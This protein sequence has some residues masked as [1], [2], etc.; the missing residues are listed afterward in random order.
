VKT[1]SAKRIVSYEF[2][3]PSCSRKWG[4]ASDIPGDKDEV[5]RL[6]HRRSVTLNCKCGKSYRVHSDNI[7]E[8]CDTCISSFMAGRTLACRKTDNETEPQSVCNEWE[9]R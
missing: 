7:T 2:S 5:D 8:E 1:A 3:C 6:E 9:V 4:L